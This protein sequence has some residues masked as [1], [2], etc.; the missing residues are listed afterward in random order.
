[1]AT[2]SLRYAR[3]WGQT[4]FIAFQT[5]AAAQ[6]CCIQYGAAQHHSSLNLTFS[7]CPRRVH[8]QVTLLEA[9]DLPAWGQSSC[10]ALAQ[11]HILTISS[12]AQ[13]TSQA[14]C[15][16]D[17]VGGPQS[18][19]VGLPLAE[20]PLLPDRGGVAVLQEPKGGCH[21]PCG[22]PPGARVEPRV[23]VSCGGPQ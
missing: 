16:G 4:L 15:A 2:R 23:P 10:S 14:V 22:Q 19:G 6:A 18:A 3:A 11:V 20:Q 1:M 8:V 12:E 17:P 21:Q 9:T 5:C 13:A 7:L